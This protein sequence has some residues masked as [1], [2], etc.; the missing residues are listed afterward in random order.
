[1]S[2]L[3][4]PEI[5]RSV[6]ESLQTGV[7]LVDRE[8]RIFFWNEG[9]EK[10]T[11]YLRQEVVGAFCRDEIF[12]K[13]PGTRNVLADAAAAL[14]E[15]M[16][17]GKPT[18]MEVSLRHKAGHRVFVRLRAVP[19]RNSQGAI[20]GAAESFEEDIS[21]SDWNRRHD[22]LAGYGCVD[23][24]T[25][26]LNQPFTLSRLRENLATFAEHRVPF[27][28][29]L[30]E[31]DGIDKLRATY[32]AAVLGTVLHVS[33]QTIEN[34]LRPTDC[35]GRYGDYRFLAILS[36]CDENELDRVAERLKRM[37]G[38]SEIKWWGDEW[39]VTASMGGTNVRAGDTVESMIERA[40]AA[41]G[42][43]LQSGGN[44]IS[45]LDRA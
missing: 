35:L 16:R 31:V 25:G 20:I 7:Y 13:E 24:V 8:R 45:V 9:A 30:V 33:A 44:A 5:Y 23:R 17:D 4:S 43:S 1:M 42:C 22:K 32:G 18:I 29:L 34:S 6:L 2:E 14:S 10:I 21:A 41:L 40:E 12:A 15:T 11:G 19:I 36:E 3:D 26:V 38:S 37:V 27:S 28:I 39:S